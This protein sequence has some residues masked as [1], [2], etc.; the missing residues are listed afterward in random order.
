MEIAALSTV[1]GKWILAVTDREIWMS[2]SPYSKRGILIWLLESHWRKRTYVTKVGT[3]E[4]ET[5][6]AP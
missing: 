2:K 4:K 6:K 3:K 1:L 5:I